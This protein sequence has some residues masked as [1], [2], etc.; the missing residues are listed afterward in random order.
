MPNVSPSQPVH[1]LLE[2][3]VPPTIEAASLTATRDSTDTVR[4]YGVPYSEHS[5]FYEL[6]A[7]V[8]SLRHIRIIPTVNVG[9]AASR[10]WMRAW[11]DQWTAA[12]RRSNGIMVPP[13]SELYW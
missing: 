1:E 6:M 10:S 9:T 4:V 5:S 8:L 12:S 3:L 7:F 11:I 2:A 13:R